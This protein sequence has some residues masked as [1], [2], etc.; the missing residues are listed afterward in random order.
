MYL[1][2]IKDIIKK[3]VLDNFTGTIS[4]VDMLLSLIVAFVIGLIIIYVYRKTY[5]G[6]FI[7]NHFHYVY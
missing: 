1:L 6:V 7:Q 5:T 4:S 2:S 3:S